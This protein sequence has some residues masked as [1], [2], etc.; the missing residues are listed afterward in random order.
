MTT[1]DRISALQ[2]RLTAEGTP[3][4]LATVV[5]TVAATAAKAGA[6]ALVLA[7]GELHGFVG[8]GCV[9]GAVRRAA[10]ACLAEGRPRLISVV[11]DAAF[12]SESGRDDLIHAGRELHRSMCP[13]GGTL[14]I[15]LEPMLPRPEL[16][17]VGTSPVA[18][19]TADLGS[20]LGFRVVVIADEAEADLFP[21]AAAVAR[22]ITILPERGDR[23]VVV[24]TQGKGDMTALRAV[25]GRELAYLA[26][27]GSRRKWKALAARLAAEGAPAEQLARIR[28]P[29][30]LDIGAILPEEIALAIL[31]EIVGL[32]R[33]RQLGAAAGPVPAQP[34]AS[35]PATERVLGHVRA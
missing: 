19:A 11:P 30:G 6:K 18:I 26:F 1:A 21:S 14:D 7:D 15:F 10:A 5:R 12:E 22:G 32:R 2:A 3:F 4:V 17:V 25:L 24:A 13:S 27:V 23:W 31:A 28:S 34:S 8:G 16:V 35:G 9:T 20:R 29:A 33:R